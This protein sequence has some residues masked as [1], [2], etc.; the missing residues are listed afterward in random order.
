MDKDDAPVANL[1]CTAPEQSQLGP[2]LFDAAHIASDPNPDGFEIP[3]AF[4][5]SN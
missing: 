4:L 2:D 1:P 5:P 3:E